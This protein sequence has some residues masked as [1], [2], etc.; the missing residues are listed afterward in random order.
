MWKRVRTG[1]ANKRSQFPLSM[2]RICMKR[3]SFSRRWCGRLK[4]QEPPLPVPLLQ[5]RRGGRPRIELESNQSNG[6]GPFAREW[7]SERRFE[8]DPSSAFRAGGGFE[9]AADILHSL[10]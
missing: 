3:N 8:S 1:V 2:M 10:A 5:R 6:S 7:A 4:E 9:L